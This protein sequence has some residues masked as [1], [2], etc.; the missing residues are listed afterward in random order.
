MSHPLRFSRFSDEGAAH[1][2]TREKESDKYVL[3]ILISA[4]SIN[5]YVQL[6]FSPRYIWLVNVILPL[7]HG[8][9]TFCEE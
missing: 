1:S 9:S 4:R 2:L 6:R 5:A 8:N 7:R 3:L